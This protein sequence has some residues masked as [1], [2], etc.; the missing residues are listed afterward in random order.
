M[1]KPYLIERSG[2]AA[3]HPGVTRARMTSF[4]LIGSCSS[5]FN[6]QSVFLLPARKRMLNHDHHH[7]SLRCSQVGRSCEDSMGLREV[8]CIFRGNFAIDTNVSLFGK[9]GHYLRINGKGFTEQL[10]SF[11]ICRLRKE[12]KLCQQ[13]RCY[14]LA[15]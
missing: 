7:R 14:I 13:K 12:L 6:F 9:K 5:G 4:C 8:I 1:G 15:G 3:R 11:A 2:I 10:N